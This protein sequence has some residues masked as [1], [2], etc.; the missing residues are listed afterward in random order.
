MFIQK[1]ESNIIN[2]LYLQFLILFAS[3]GVYL[4]YLLKEQ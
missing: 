3:W 2:N 1:K 4:F